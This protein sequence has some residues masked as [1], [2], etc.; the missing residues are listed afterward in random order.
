MIIE[1]K[2][3]KIIS[4]SNQETYD[5]GFDMAKHCQ[6][7]EVFLLNGDLGSGKTT[8]LQG[9]GAG[10]GYKNKINSP[11]FNIMKLYSIQG[12]RG[13]N[14]FCHIDA[15]RLNSGSDLLA[16]GIDEYLNNK[17]V[18]TAIEWSEKV[19]S[20]WPQNSIVITIKSI[21]ENKREIEIIK[22]S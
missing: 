5:L 13:L 10:L 20:I 9:L 15:Y 7:G 19:K 14:F 18:V 8:L 3:Q 22:N 16:L 2:K 6:G 12:D 1:N 11:T 21:S 4:N 17:E